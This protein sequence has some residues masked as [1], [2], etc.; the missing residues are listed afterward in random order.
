MN[1]RLGT[2]Q[3]WDKDKTGTWQGQDRGKT[4]TRH[5][6]YREKKEIRQKQVNKRQGKDRDKIREEEG[7]NSSAARGKEQ[8]SYFSW[9]CLCERIKRRGKR[10]K[11]RR[12]K[13]ERVEN[14]KRRRMRWRWR[15][16]RMGRRE[17]LCPLIAARYH[18]F[19]SKHLY[20][21]LYH[22]ILYTIYSC[23]IPPLPIQQTPTRLCNL[24]LSSTSQSPIPKWTKA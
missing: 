23:K 5:G 24:R 22:I 10:L 7:E 1:N 4:G 3:G 21:V 20:F 16:H 6:D 2:I 13:N 12:W 8:P 18:L 11:Q 14:L 19:L 15:R 9:D 17:V